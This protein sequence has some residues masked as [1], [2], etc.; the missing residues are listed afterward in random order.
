M[1]RKTTPS[2]S[3]AYTNLEKNIPVCLF[4]DLFNGNPVMKKLSLYAPNAGWESVNFIISSSLVSHCLCTKMG[5]C[6]MD[7]FILSRFSFSIPC[8]FVDSKINNKKVRH[9]HNLYID[10]LFIYIMPKIL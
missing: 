8:D 7:S 4:I 10:Q 3:L 6:L 5:V 1:E 2:Q 9:I